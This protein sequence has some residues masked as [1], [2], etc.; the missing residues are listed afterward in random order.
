MWPVWKGEE[1]EGKSISLDLKYFIKRAMTQWVYVP[2]S[3][4]LQEEN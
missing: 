3:K 4:N 2:D 1:T